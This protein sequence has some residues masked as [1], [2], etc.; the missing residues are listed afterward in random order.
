MAGTVARGVEDPVQIGLEGVEHGEPV[1][2]LRGIE[3]EMAGVRAAGGEIAV[4]D[5]VDQACVAV[6]GHQVVT[7]GAG[8]EEGGYGEILVRG[9]VESAGHDVV[10]VR[11]PGTGHHG[12]PGAGTA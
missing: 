2:G 4:A 9:L 7:P 11:L 3:A 1:V 5:V 8:Q 12:P 6:D 10:G